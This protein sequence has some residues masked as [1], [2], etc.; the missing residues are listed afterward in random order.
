VSGLPSVQGDLQQLL[1]P[2]ALAAERLRRQR[3]RL[4]Q[5][6][7]ENGP[8]RREL[9]PKHLQFF[10]AGGQH[11]P[12]PGCCPPECDGR[13]HRERCFIAGNRCLTPWTP[14]ETGH[15]TRQCREL[16]GER[17]FDVRSWDGGSR[18]TRKASGLFLKSISPAFRVHLDNGQAFDC[19]RKHLLLTTAGWLS[20][21]QIV[22]NAS[23]LHCT[24]TASGSEASYAVDDYQRGELLPRFQGI[25][26]AQLPLLTGVLP[27]SRYSWLV[28]GVEPRFGYSHAYPDFYPGSSH[29]DPDQLA[30]LIGQFEDPTLR[31]DA[32]WP[33]GLRQELKRFADE[34]VLQQAKRGVDP[35]ELSWDLPLE[36][37][38]RGVYRTHEG[39]ARELRGSLLCE[40]LD[41]PDPSIEGFLA[42]GPLEQILFP[43]EHPRLVGGQRIVSI[44][45][46][47][48]QPIV[49]FTVEQ[50][51]CYELGGVISHNCGKT[52]AG[53]Y[54][55]TLHLTGKYPTWWVGR[56]FDKHIKAW[57]ASDTSKTVRSV[58]QEKFLGPPNA[59]G[60]GMIPADDIVYSTA[61]AGIA[62]A[63]DTIYVKHAS[64]GVSSVQLKSYQ[65]GRESFQ[66]DTIDFVLLDEEPSLEIFAEALVRTM[67]TDG[68]IALVF[69]PLQGLS[70]VVLSFMPEGAQPKVTE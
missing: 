63:V 69:T 53:V 27:H 13:A 41:S 38:H 15:A 29:D 17:G 56:R 22:R 50:T 2:A 3:N 26:Q 14:I 36:R 31:L 28:D 37:Q 61:K 25:D 51:H 70:E 21:D 58:L 5:I 45:P 30:D 33:I 48:Y 11:E 57:A 20:F 16:F 46:L 60:T 8:F 55:A 32:Q 24:R 34:C 44:V 67:S 4:D 42:S 64:G 65:E 1:N 68:Q 62:E 7:P 12:I 9:Y 66:A 43:T 59:R 54:E 19:S 49:D 6:F 35:L 39:L 40:W 23:G 47:G 52:S 18:C 10:A